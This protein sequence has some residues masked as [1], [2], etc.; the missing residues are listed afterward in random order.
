MYASRRRNGGTRAHRGVHRWN[1]TRAEAGDGA[2]DGGFC[3][4]HELLSK[5]RPHSGNMGRDQQL[6]HIGR[7]V[8]W[9][10]DQSSGMHLHQTPVMVM[11]VQAAIHKFCS[12][13]VICSITQSEVTRT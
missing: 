12:H 7:T 8:L 11:N 10:Q 6:V 9:P 5:P 4:G 13:A 1:A 3:W 2:A